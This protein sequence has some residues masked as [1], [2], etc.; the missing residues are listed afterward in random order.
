M[1]SRNGEEQF[2]ISSK[3]QNDGWIFLHRKVAG[4]RLPD[5]ESFP[6]E[7]PSAEASYESCS[8]ETPMPS[9]LGCHHL[10]VSPTN[11]AV[12]Q[13][14]FDID[15]HQLMVH[16]GSHRLPRVRETVGPSANRLS[17]SWFA[18]QLHFHMGPFLL[19]N[20]EGAPESNAW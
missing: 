19:K 4:K 9:A 8:M 17:A 14:G 11:G 10:W 2:A 7:L 5:S 16:V 18:M 6:Q 13:V 12:R 20:L 3:F 1:K 15:Q